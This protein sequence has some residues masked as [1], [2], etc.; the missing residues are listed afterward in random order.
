MGMESISGTLKRL[1]M[2]AGL[3][4]AEL[5]RHSGVHYSTISRLE[6]GDLTRPGADI[7]MR[8]AQALGVEISGLLG[9][10]SPRDGDLS[11]DLRLRLQRLRPHFR[12]QFDMLLEQGAQLADTPEDLAA[13]EVAIRAACDSLE[14]V[15]RR[16]QER[17]KNT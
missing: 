11:E 13:F 17:D 12:I 15:L 8:L 9:A 5:A 10:T 16:R 2:A 1:R 6:S 4:P 3:S 7:T 14:L